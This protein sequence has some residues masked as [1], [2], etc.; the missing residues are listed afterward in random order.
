MFEL[1]TDIRSDLKSKNLGKENLFTPTYKSGLDLLDYRNG[2]YD[3][4]ESLRLGF[5][6]GKIFTII[7]KSG[8]GKST[9][10]LQI[11]GNIIDNSPNSNLIYL[12]Y[13]R[14]L[15]P[16]RISAI[17]GWTEKERQEKSLILNSEISTETLLQLVYSISETKNK[18]ENYN[19]IKIDSGKMDRDGNKIYTLP[20]TVII[21]DSIA[22]MI[23]KD[24]ATGEEISGSM[25]ASA[26]AK[27]NNQVIKKSLSYLEK[28]NILL[29]AVNHIT[30]NIQTGIV[31]EAAQINYL[32]QGESLPGKLNYCLA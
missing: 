15:K 27:I 13:E 18:K 24:F 16:A 8:V 19:E 5:D 12:D 17:T 14:A 23:P 11:A 30:T 4:D 1:L 3:E 20:P 9:L 21:L 7:G 29:I 10:A 22:T 31:K 28:G 25:E 32:K 2:F 6:G 26:I